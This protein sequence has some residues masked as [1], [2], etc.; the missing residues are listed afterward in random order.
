MQKSKWIIFSQ[1]SYYSFLKKVLKNTQVGCI[2]KIK[3]MIKMLKLFILL[4]TS[5]QS[6]VDNLIICYVDSM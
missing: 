6:F 3:E 2:E 5:F 1:F 4:P